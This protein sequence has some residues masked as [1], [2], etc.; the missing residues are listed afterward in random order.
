MNESSTNNDPLFCQKCLTILFVLEAV[1]K[2]CISCL[3]ASRGV[4]EPP[5]VRIRRMRISCAKSIGFRFGIRHIPSP[6]II[7]ANYGNVVTS[8]R[9]FT[10]KA[11]EKS[12]VFCFSDS[13]Q[14]TGWTSSKLRWSRQVWNKNF[15]S[16]TIGF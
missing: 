12:N 2:T 10:M 13:F 6:L 7:L 11:L 16:N 1:W 14:K 4:T 15:E 8:L 3:V 9:E 5:K